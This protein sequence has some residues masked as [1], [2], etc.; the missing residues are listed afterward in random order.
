MVQV[1]DKCIGC[2]VCGMTA[3]TIFKVEGVPAT[4]IKQPETPEEQAAVD[5]A[6][7]SCPTKA[8]SK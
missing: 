8:I 6:I 1:D 2:G 3:P 5:Q 4:V 7:E